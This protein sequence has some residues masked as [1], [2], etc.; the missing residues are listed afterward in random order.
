MPDPQRFVDVFSQVSLWA[1]VL[2]FLLGLLATFSPATFALTPVIVGYVGAGARSRPA[3][4]GRALSFVGGLSLVNVA[5]GALFGAAGAFAQRLTGGNLALWNLLAGLLTLVM[6]LAAL[7]LIRL[8]FPSLT[9]PDAPRAS[10]LGAFLLGLPF[11]LVS[12]PTCMPLLVSVA[13]GAAST[14][15]AWYGALLFL[16]FAIGRGIP[17][18]ALGGATGMFKNL[19]GV[20]RRMPVIERVSAFVMLAAA[21]FFLIEAVRWWLWTPS[22]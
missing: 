19:R 5:I 22:M 8:P 18:L 13:I 7:D 10:W 9:E 16:A 20:A 21:V 2:S 6:A 17:L 3:A 11:G 15:A 4:W 12:C 14:G 1:V